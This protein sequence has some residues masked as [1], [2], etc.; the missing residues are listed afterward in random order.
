MEIFDNLFGI[1]LIILF[2]GGSIFVH[3]LGHFLAARWRGLKIERFSIGIGP[4]IFGWTGKDGVDYRL[5]LFPIGGYVALPQ[6]G[7][8]EAVEGKNE[9]DPDELPPISYPDKIYVAVAGVVFNII[10]AFLLACVLWVSGRP[11]PP[12]ANTTTIGYVLKEL[13]NQSGPS[14]A[15]AAGLLPGDKVLAVDGSAVDDFRQITNKVALGGGRDDKGNPQVVLTISRGGKKLDVPVSPALVDLNPS[16]GDRIRM[17]GISPSNTLAIERVEPNSPA[18]RAGFKTGD[19]ILSLEGAFVFSGSQFREKLAAASLHT[20]LTTDDKLTVEKVEPASPAERA[21][22]KPGDVIAAFDG[23]PVANRAQFYEKLLASGVREIRLTVREGGIARSDTLAPRL[24]EVRVGVRGADG[25][26]REIAVAP[27][28]RAELASYFEISFQEKGALR[29]VKLACVPDNALAKQEP[30][31]SAPRNSLMVFDSDVASDSDFAGVLRPGKILSRIDQHGTLLDTPT[32]ET[33]AR[34]KPSDTADVFFSDG[35]KPATFEKFSVAAVPAKK[36][37]YIGVVFRNEA[38]I[39]HQNPLEQMR[40][41]FALTYDSIAALAN[42]KTDV[43]V[44][45][46]M[47]VVSIGRIYYNMSDDLRRILWFTLVININLAILNILP[48][49]VLDG[50]HILFATIQRIRRRPLP[51]SIV[52][53]LQYV[54]IVL[55]VALMGYIV[56]YKD[57]MRWRGD[58]ILED[59]SRIVRRYVRVPEKPFA[60]KAETAKP[61]ATPETPAAK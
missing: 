16:S 12:N 38:E 47:G 54:F 48:L 25:K 44:G 27:E 29:T 6:L 17:V 40:A 33:L 19:T 36:S 22:L 7:D 2:F 14:P 3:E 24:R 61:A 10:F 31:A 59:Q 1:A 43:G 45:Q 5:S 39:V 46:L 13:P 32:P 4:R 18:E 34:L 56:L 57:L 26:E 15:T 60:A 23:A 58:N 50:G 35:G 52:A 8:M 30:P 9:S 53:G 42:P 11:V 49:P 28:A 20:G 55:F 41:A 37:P 51:I 21:G